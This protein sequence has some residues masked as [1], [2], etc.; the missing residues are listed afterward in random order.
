ME[1]LNSPLDYDILLGGLPIGIELVALESGA[2]NFILSFVYTR[3]E[4]GEDFP[5][6]QSALG[7]SGMLWISW[8][9]KKPVL[10]QI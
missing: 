4:L 6:Y 1:M 2:L 9:K 7:Q 3:K 8:P 5:S 10:L